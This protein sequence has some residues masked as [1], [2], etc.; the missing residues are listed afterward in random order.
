MGN[1][2]VNTKYLLVSGSF[3]SNRERDCFVTTNRRLIE[4]REQFPE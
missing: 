1:P 4:N 3:H 2:A